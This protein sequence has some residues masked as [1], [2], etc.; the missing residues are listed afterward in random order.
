MTDFLLERGWWVFS[1]SHGYHGPVDV[2]AFRADPTYSLLLEVKC[3]NFRVNPRRNK[4][5]RIYR[6]RSLLQKELGVVV[7]YVNIEE[8]KLHFTG[9]D[10]MDDELKALLI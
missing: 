2:C 5:H 4:P 3:D 8:N 7:V 1:Q 9:L 10:E 6:P